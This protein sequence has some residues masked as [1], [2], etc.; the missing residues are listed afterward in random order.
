[1]L[2]F[3]LGHSLEG[4]LLGDIVICC[5]VVK[6]EAKQ[7]Q[8]ILSHHYAHLFIHGILHLQGYDQITHTQANEMESL[9]IDIL[10]SL[11]IAN[12]YSSDDTPS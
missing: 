6:D 10:R 7:Q 9:E 11:N 4:K 3:E 2:T 8:K 12:P 1:V 5:P